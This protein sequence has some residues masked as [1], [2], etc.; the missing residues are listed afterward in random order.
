MSEKACVQLISNGQGTG[1]WEVWVPVW[2]LQDCP[3]SCLCAASSVCR[4]IYRHV[5][6]PGEGGANWVELNPDIAKQMHLEEIAEAL[7]LS[8]RPAR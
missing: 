6:H 1:E 7:T 2:V 5:C 3:S 8:S 4:H